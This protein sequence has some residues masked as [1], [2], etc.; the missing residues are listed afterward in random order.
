MHDIQSKNEDKLYI[1]ENNSNKNYKSDKS[2][3]NTSIEN[4][5]NKLNDDY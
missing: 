2:K 1:I 5:Q 3:L 4:Y